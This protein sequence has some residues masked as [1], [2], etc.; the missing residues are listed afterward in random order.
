MDS[1]AYDQHH[2][3][4]D[5]SLLWDS[6]R[7]L[8]ASPEAGAKGTAG[9]GLAHRYHTQAAKWLFTFLAR[10]GKEYQPLHPAAGQG[11]L[12]RAD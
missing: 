9:L 8:A 5:A 10:N 7:V 3:L 6:Y 4:T 1:T 12:P 11:A 2:F